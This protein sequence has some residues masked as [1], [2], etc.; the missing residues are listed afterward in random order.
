MGKVSLYD[1]DVVTWSEQQVSALRALAARPDLSNAVDWSNV[2]EEIE[3]V[4]RSEWKGVESQI[5]NALC[6]IIKAFGDPTSLSARAWE[7]ETERFLDDARSDYR[8]SMRHVID[9]QR[10]WERAFRDA[11]RD[12][13]LHHVAVPPG[14][15]VKCPF[16]LDDIVDPSFTHSTAFAR[17]KARRTE[18]GA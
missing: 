14:L 12:L 11:E 3:C 7:I 16:G 10:A 17:L 5:R 6:H 15:P 13:R 2:I 9:V 18:T 1:D 8:P 4:G